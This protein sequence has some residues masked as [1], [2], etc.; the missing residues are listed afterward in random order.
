ME[1][2]APKKKFKKFSANKSSKSVKTKKPSSSDEE[3]NESDEYN[4]SNNSEMDQNDSENSDDDDVCFIKYHKIFIWVFLLMIIFY[5][6]SGMTK[7]NQKI[8]KV[9]VDQKKS[10]K[11][12]Q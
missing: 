7:K 3:E 9:N 5:E 2:K 12:Y 1:K 8:K 10:Q 4:S 11:N 6:Y